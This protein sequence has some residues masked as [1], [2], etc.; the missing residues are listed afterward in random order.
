MADKH[1]RRG[2]AHPSDASRSSRSSFTQFAR[3]RP[4]L[5]VGV[6][7]ALG[8][9]LGALLPWS[10]IGDELLGDKAAKLKDGAL[11]MASDGYEKAKS[12]ARSGYEA[13]TEI[14][15]GSERTTDSGESGSIGHPGQGETRIAANQL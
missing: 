9:A 11:E 8:M 10:R 7:V 2:A 6:A 15:H 13:A 14:V 12:V 3:D 5:V 4:L 1:A